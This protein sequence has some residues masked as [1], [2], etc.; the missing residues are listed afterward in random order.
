M[1]NNYYF[2]YYIIKFL[3]DV[4]SAY[5]GEGPKIKQIKKK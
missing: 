2:F 3:L 1:K 5:G 4:V